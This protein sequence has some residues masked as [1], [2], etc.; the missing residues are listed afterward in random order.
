MAILKIARM[1]QPILR[2]TA[3]P[4]PDPTA[5]EVR[6][7][8]D[9]MGETMRDA[10]GV[11]LAAPQVYQGLRVIVFRAPADRADDESGETPETVLINPAIKPLSDELG[12]GWEGCLSVPGFRGLVAR[13]RHIAYAGYR[14][15]GSFVE[16]EAHGFLARVIQHEYDHLDG[17]LYIDRMHDLRLLVCEDEMADFRYEDYLEPEDG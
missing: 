8:I 13:W 10:P 14:P 11:G 16:G 15:D 12:L 3:E 17:F 1:G 9:D 5:P 2:R 6:R 7:L 4:V